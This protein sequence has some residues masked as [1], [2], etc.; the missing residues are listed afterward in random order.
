[1][2]D[3]AIVV[4]TRG[5]EGV[6]IH[7]PAGVEEI[8]P[9]PANVVDTTGAGDCFNGVF[10]AGL[11]EGRLLREAVRRAVVAAALSVSRA[12]ARDGMPTREEIDTALGG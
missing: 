1:M 9:F 12:G 7:D 8:P 3:G 10:A 6:R 2:P 5:A 4:E 11:L